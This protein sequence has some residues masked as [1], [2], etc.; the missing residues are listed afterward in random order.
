MNIELI[1]VT[2]IKVFRS[3]NGVTAWVLSNYEKIISKIKISIFLLH[4]QDDTWEISKTAY[5]MTYT[6][7]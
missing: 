1:S 3:G 4:S 6:V 5:A 2:Q 7:D